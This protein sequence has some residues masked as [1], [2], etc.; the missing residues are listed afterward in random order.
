M[1]KLYRC[2]MMVFVFGLLNSGILLTN[3]SV[4]NQGT[5]TVPKDTVP[6]DTVPKDT[7][8]KDTV[9]KDTVPKDTVPKDTVPKDT[10]PK[11]TVPKDTVPKD[12]VPKDTVPKDTVPKDTV[13]GTVRDYEGHVY[14]TV[15][16]G[17]QTWTVENVRSTKY[18]DGT[19]ILNITD[20][21]RWKACDS[22][23]QAAYCSYNN[24]TNADTIRKYGLLYNWY[25]VNPANP[26]KLAP[27]GWHV[28]TEADWEKLQ[29]Y[30]I[31]NGYNWDGVKTG[32]GIAKS[33]AATAGW[34]LDAIPGTIGDNPSKNNRSG[35]SQVP[36][37]YREPTGLFTTQGSVGVAWTSTQ[38]DLILAYRQSLHF[39][40]AAL[41]MAE[42]DKG[43]GFV[44]RLIK[45]Q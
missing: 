20:A 14:H 32:N 30:L 25:V 12:T 26:H 9:P 34:D 10:V 15:K 44:V 45:D 11:D 19:P 21:T 8:P 7:V 28:A 2:A 31:A 37:G 43:Y 17:S 40:D 35:F 36:A 41:L 29:N 33:L 18:T 16:I 5:D 23:K 38:V 22:T 1:S 39:D 6:K 4:N 3:C 24:V 42:R 27:F 13:P